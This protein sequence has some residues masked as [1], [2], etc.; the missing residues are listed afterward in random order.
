MKITRY[1]Y[2]ICFFAPVAFLCGYILGAPRYTPPSLDTARIDS[3]ALPVSVA[4]FYKNEA[5]LTDTGENKWLKPNSTL[6][7]R[8]KQ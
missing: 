7:D 1:L 3:R 4:D 5:T 8:V 2:L 6:A